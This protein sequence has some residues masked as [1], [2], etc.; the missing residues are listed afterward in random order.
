MATLPNFDDQ[1]ASVRCKQISLR[2]MNHRVNGASGR[3]YTG[4]L[5]SAGYLIGGIPCP[6]LAEHQTSNAKT[7]MCDVCVAM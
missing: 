7:S 6:R 3:E 1:Q 4:S 2:R 5:A